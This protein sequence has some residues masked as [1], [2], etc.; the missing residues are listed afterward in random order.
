MP[1]MRRDAAIAAALRVCPKGD[2]R[3]GHA[4]VIQSMLHSA[5]RVSPDIVMQPASVVRTTDSTWQTARRQ[6]GDM[7]IA[8]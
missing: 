5:R 3:T 8:T 7:F 2:C 6:A 4:L 1:V